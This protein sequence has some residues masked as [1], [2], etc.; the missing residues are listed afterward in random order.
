[1][2]TGLADL[3]AEAG[4]DPR[5]RGRA[6]E[7]ICKWYL[8]C[9]AEYRLKLRHVWPRSEWPNRWNNLDTGIDIVAETFEGDVWAIQAKAVAATREISKAEIDSFL[10]DSN[11]AEFSFRLLL[12]TTD[13]IGRNARQTLEAQ[14]KK[15]GLKLLADLERADVDWPASLADLRP[16]APRRHECRPHQLEAVAAIS[17]G[18]AVA[19]RGRVTMACGTGKTLVGQRVAEKLESS[20]TLVLVPSI[21]L[22]AQII[23][24]WSRDATYPFSYQ[25]VCS[26]DEVVGERDAVV[27]SPSELG[28]PVTTE[29][30]AIHRFLSAPTDRPRVV[31]STYH[32]S[33]RIAEA[34]A[35]SGIRFDLVIADEA[36]RCAGVR[37]GPF[38]VVL[39]DALIPAKRRL[40]MTATPRYMSNRVVKEAFESGYAVVSMDDHRVFGPTL[41]RLAFSE[42]IQRKL[43]SD[44]RVV[45]VAVDDSTYRD[46]AESG[47]FVSRDGGKPEDARSLAAQLALVRAI[48]NFDLKRLVSFHSR[49][50][51]A[52]AFSKS[53]PEVW[54]WVPADRKAQGRLTAEYVSG[55][56]ASGERESRLSRLKATSPGHRRLLSNARCLTEGVDV[57]VLDGVVFID[58]RRSQVDIVQAVGRAL[59]LAED[60]AHGTIVLPVFL[61]SSEDDV[62]VLESS[63][64]ETVW[65]VLRALRAHDDEL[66]DEIDEIRREMGRRRGSA[67]RPG[68]V[69]L[70]L[71]EGV[72]EDFARAFDTRLV[73]VVSQTWEYWFGLLSAFVE[74]EGNARV[75]TFHLEEGQRLG[76]WV[77]VQRRFEAAGQLR[78]DRRDR[79]AGLPGWTW[80]ARDDLWDRAFQALDRYVKREGT[81]NVPTPWK[82][83]GFP[84]GDWIANQRRKHI[85][86][87]LGNSRSAK[88]AEL[89]GWTWAAQDDSWDKGFASAKRFL[90]EHG[91]ITPAQREK[92]HGYPVGHWIAT[93][94]EAYTNGRLAADRAERLQS[95]SGWRWNVLD[96]KWAEGL[97]ALRQYTDRT[98]TAAVPLL[99]KEDG[100]ALGR[101][102]AKQR[103]NFRSGSL[104]LA[105]TE[106]LDSIP[107]WQWDP[108]DAE[109]EKAFAHLTAFAV[110]EGHARVPTKH[111]EHGFPLGA[112]A[113]RQRQAHK[114]GTMPTSRK[115]RLEAVPGWIWDA[116]ELRPGGPLFSKRAA[117]Q[118]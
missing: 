7:R 9:A 95:L 62:A 86:G 73:E 106:L 6:F 90:E 32:S 110:R 109:W 47:R 55:E 75:G 74:R 10:S 13:R 113:A 114:A 84:L 82:E 91:H 19:D 67:R 64:F 56:M 104:G 87:E 103:Q 26:D 98:G 102:V 29:S 71:P 88:L 101:W 52:R 22:V 93:Q 30:Q 1:L 108:L 61:E 28:V 11:R 2:P 116:R 97:S 83:R 53:L 45:V 18:L 33:S 78:P 44:Y 112:W 59:R 12:A 66:A 27:A 51:D 70:E 42:A 8:E 23:R 76:Q 94:R 4:D 63:V 111:S 72:G 96:A 80:D 50:E 39:D 107:G 68:R 48:T 105:R 25:A 115:T 65:K 49:I 34:C 37:A 31:F 38:A 69:S 118:K 5:A 36:H 35:L 79:L 77:G 85:R 43:L 100:F 15:V 14:E 40:F 99:W 58:P 92:A 20:L 21:T 81:A 117:L 16:A 17:A 60:K 3:L 24:E 41:Y 54:D 46:Y 57:P 89:P